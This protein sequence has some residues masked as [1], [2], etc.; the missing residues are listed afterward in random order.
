MSAIRGAGVVT[1][2]AIYVIE[3]YRTMISPLRPPSCR[4]IPTCSH[5][6]MEALAE[7]GFLRGTWF[8]LVRLGKCGPWNQGGWDPIPQRSDSGCRH[9]A[10]SGGAVESVTLRSDSIV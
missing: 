10:D 9:V 6:A 5:Y 7:F 3:L 8:A 1:S 2:A 4:F